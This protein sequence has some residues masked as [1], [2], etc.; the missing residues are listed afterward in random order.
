MNGMVNVVLY[1]PRY[2]IDYGHHDMALAFY[3]TELRGMEKPDFEKI[4]PAVLSQYIPV[5]VVGFLLA[6]LLAAFMS[7]FAATINAAPAYIVNDIYK[8]FINPNASAKRYVGLSRLASLAVLV[9][10]VIFGLMTSSIYEIMSWVAGALYGAYVMANVLKWIWWRFNGYGYFW[11]MLTGVASAMLIPELVNKLAP[12]Q[13][14][15]A[16]YYFPVI[17]GVSVIGCLLGT[18]LTQPEDD[19]IL[20]SF[21]KTVN[22]WGFWGPIREKV[23]REDPSFVPNH[24]F[25]KDCINV[26]VGI[27]WQLCLTACRFTSCCRT[28]LGLVM[29]GARS[30]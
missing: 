25:G 12:D 21:Y 16:L 27:L 30:S 7:N 5:G 28:G 13:H 19:A 14:V 11:G 18:L 1:F 6:G 17:F 15:N 20:M 22:P 9:V 29:W 10:G 8:R 4:L 3:M 24:H 2:M 26:M 23:M